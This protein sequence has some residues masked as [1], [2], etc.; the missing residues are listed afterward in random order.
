MMLDDGMFGEYQLAHELRKT[1][2]EI[3]EMTHIEYLG[4]CSYFARRAAE[5]SVS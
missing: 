2:A 4:W 5:S 3:N 1:V